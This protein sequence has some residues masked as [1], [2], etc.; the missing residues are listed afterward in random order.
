MKY[1]SIFQIMVGLIAVFNLILHYTSG[2]YI[3]MGGWIIVLIECT[4]VISIVE[5]PK[6]GIV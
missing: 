2:N 3:A 1:Q 5:G 4:L 6:E